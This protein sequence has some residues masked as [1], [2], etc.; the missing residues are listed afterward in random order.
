MATPY[1]ET[2]DRYT[3]LCAALERRLRA[4]GANPAP[5]AAAASAVINLHVD[6]TGR[7]PRSSWRA[8]R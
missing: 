5:N 2:R 1:I 7:A 6:D 4:A 8:S 3:A